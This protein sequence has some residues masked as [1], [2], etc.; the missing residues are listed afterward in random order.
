MALAF[1]NMAFLLLPC[2]L[3]AQGSNYATMPSVIRARAYLRPGPG[4]A[5]FTLKLHQG[6]SDQWLSIT[7]AHGPARYL[8]VDDFE[9][10]SSTGAGENPSILEFG[11]FNFDGYTDFPIEAFRGTTGND[12]HFY[13]LFHPETSTFPFHAGWSNLSQPQFLPKLKRIHAHWN[14]GNAGGDRKDSS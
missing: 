1:R 3:H 5:L 7:P 12:G 9:K 13:F 10:L 14:A 2:L 11:D 8:Q 4:Q 6:R